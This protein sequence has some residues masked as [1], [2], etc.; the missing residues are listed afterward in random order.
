MRCGGDMIV[1]VLKEGYFGIKENNLVVIVY[2]IIA[3]LQGMVHSIQNM[4]HLREYVWGL[5]TIC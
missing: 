1:L 5:G 2:D 3:S 4:P